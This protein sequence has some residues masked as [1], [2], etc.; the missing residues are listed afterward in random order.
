[1]PDEDGYSLISKV[2]ALPAERLARIPAI[3]VTAFARPED[4]SQAIRAGFQ[5]H[6]SKPVDPAQLI[7]LVAGL[8]GR[9]LHRKKA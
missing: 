4:R 1:M 7:A 8:S 3:A 9:T 2:R 6:V 5:A